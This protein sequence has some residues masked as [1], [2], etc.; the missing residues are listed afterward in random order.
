MVGEWSIFCN[1]AGSTVM[2]KTVALSTVLRTK[3][4]GSCY[5]PHAF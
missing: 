2:F 5:T 3:F 1:D 4:V